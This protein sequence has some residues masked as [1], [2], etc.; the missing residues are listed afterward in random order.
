[1]K[2]RATARKIGFKPF[3][4]TAAGVYGTE[5]W[6]NLAILDSSRVALFNEVIDE[7][8]K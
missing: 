3:D 2:S 4:A 6:K 8:E 7:K 5:D 1:L